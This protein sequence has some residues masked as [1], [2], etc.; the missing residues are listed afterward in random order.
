MALYTTTVEEICKSF[1]RI[2]L[3]D[4]DP[5]TMTVD[6]I[7]AAAEPFIFNFEYPSF[8]SE[9]KT[10]VEQLILNQYYTEEI[11]AETEA[12]WQQLLKMR[13]RLTMPYYIQLYEAEQIELDPLAGDKITDTT[14]D[15]TDT[16]NEDSY[17]SS[18]NSETSRSGS[19]TNRAVR[20]ELPNQP[21]E[22]SDLTGEFYASQATLTTDSQSSTDTAETS[23][24]GSSNA[25]GKVEKNTTYNRSIVAGNQAEAIMKYRESMINIDQMIVE[26]LSDLFMSLWYTYYSR[27]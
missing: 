27:G 6:E 11:C 3:P 25:T 16:T 18:S 17:T 12:L 13:L 5:E 1:I 8:S 19:G 14:A 20:S 2:N 9:Q 23:G 22:L 10:R 24:S 21:M 15:V 7:V 4:K 26:S